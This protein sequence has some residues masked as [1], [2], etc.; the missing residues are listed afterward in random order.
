MLIAG[1]INCRKWLISPG[2]VFRWKVQW[3][4]LSSL[5]IFINF[6]L[7]PFRVQFSPVPVSLAWNVKAEFLEREVGKESGLRPLV[8]WVYSGWLCLSWE[9]RCSLAKLLSHAR[10]QRNSLCPPGK[11]ASSTPCLRVLSSSSSSWWLEAWTGKSYLDCH[12]LH[13]LSRVCFLWCVMC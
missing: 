2:Q 3:P 12:C 10:G 9:Q 13:A 1:C 11:Q 8:C 7:L 4:F 5:V 6:M